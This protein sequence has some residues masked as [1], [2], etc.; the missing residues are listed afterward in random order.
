MEPMSSSNEKSTIS[1][2]RLMGA[3]VVVVVLGFFLVGPGGLI[4]EIR[5]GQLAPD[6]LGPTTDGSEFHLHDA[7]G[8]L[9]LLDF[10]ASWCEWCTKSVP[11]IEQIRRTLADGYPQLRVVGINLKEDLATARQAAAQ[12]GM[13]YPSVLDI[14]G[15]ITEEYRAQGIPLFVLLDTDRTV[16]WRQN[17]YSDDIAEQIREAVL[18]RRAQ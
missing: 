18:A 5:N 13:G 10:W 12:F 4:H 14:D 1:S 2:R 16:L 8:E 6:I 11:Q 7:K 15:A 3:G 9:V 17:G